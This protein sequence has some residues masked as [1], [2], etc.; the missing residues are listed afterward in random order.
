MKTFEELVV[1][2]LVRGRGSLI[3]RRWARRFAPLVVAAIDASVLSCCGA[4]SSLSAAR[5]EATE[6]MWHHGKNGKGKR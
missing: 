5:V 6:A 3:K 2:A 4:P 1:D